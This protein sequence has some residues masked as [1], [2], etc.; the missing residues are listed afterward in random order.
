MPSIPEAPNPDP[1]NL[2]RAIPTGGRRTSIW[3][4]VIGV[5]LLI[6]CLPF[7]LPADRDVLDGKYTT[8]N[9]AA[10][11]TV[12]TWPTWKLDLTKLD[13]T[14][15]APRTQPQMTSLYATCGATDFQ[16]LGMSGV[17]PNGSQASIEHSVNRAFRAA[18]SEK[19]DPL[20]LQTASAKELFAPSLASEIATVLLSDT[21]TYTYG[22]S[23]PWDDGSSNLNGGFGGGVQDVSYS[24]VASSS[25]KAVSGTAVAGRTKNIYVQTAAFVQDSA[26]HTMYFVI[27]SGST[28][29]RVENALS[30]LLGRL[31]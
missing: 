20:D 13:S 28:P 6:F 7:A 30:S 1:L 26:D 25:V 19:Q 16:L 17:D 2:Y 10:A 3:F 22:G 14:C 8:L 12:L 9:A 4:G 24:P 29:Q 5:A 31:R 11:D 23:S 27:V 18:W 21:M 15:R